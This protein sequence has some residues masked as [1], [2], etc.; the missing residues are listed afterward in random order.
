MSDKKESKQFE[1]LNHRNY[2][3]W[4]FRMKLFLK[5]EKCWEVIE[6]ENRPANVTA[7]KWTDM[8]EKANYLLSIYIENIQLP[9]I[10][11]TVTAKNAWDELAKHHKKS[12]LSTKIRLLRKLYHEILPRNMTFIYRN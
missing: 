9:F 6:H 4:S 1:K 5:N 2:N 10:K 8:E 7:R 12:S 3:T 11:R